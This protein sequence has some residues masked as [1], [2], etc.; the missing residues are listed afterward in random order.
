MNILE[1]IKKRTTIRKYKKKRIPITII[2]SII[3]A[4]IWSSSLHGF[5]P[6]KFVVISNKKLIKSLSL[7]LLNKSRRIGTGANIIL[8]SSAN[9]IANAK[10]LIIIYNSG[11]FVKLVNKF[12]GL[13]AQVAKIAE[14][15]AISAAIQNMILMADNLGISSCWLSAPLFCK[16]EVNKLFNTSD[17]LVAVLTLGYS[18]EKSKRSRRKPLFQTVKY[19]R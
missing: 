2:N 8:H 12:N 13:Y 7:I 17:E 4:G 16:K 11:E 19:L 9:T 15:S 3:E 5:Q 6:W 18:A 14:L 10:V 1:L